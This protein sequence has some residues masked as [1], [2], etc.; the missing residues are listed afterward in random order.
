MEKITYTC[1]CGIEPRIVRIVKCP[2][3]KSERIGFHIRDYYCKD[4][5]HVFEEKDAV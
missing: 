2:K 5:G 4:C 3:C 1:T